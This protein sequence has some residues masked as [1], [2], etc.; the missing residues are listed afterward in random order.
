MH[1]LTSNGLVVYL[2]VTVRGRLRR[3]EPRAVTDAQLQDLP[4]TAVSSHIA[5]ITTC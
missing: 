3:R 2:F 5:T 1:S 4:C